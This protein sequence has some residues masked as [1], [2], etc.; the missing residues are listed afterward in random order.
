[1][2]LNILQLHT[3]TLPSPGGLEQ[4]LEK[5]V[6]YFLVATLLYFPS[7]FVIEP[8]SQLWHA[9]EVNSHLDVPPDLGPEDIALGPGQQVNTLDDV[10]EDFILTVLDIVRSPGDCIGHCWGWLGGRL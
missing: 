2:E 5:E 8:Q 6:K 9:R 10:Q 7:Y 4:H 3:L 1:M